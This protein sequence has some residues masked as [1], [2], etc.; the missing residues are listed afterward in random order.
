[1][2]KHEVRILAGDCENKVSGPYWS[3]LNFV[4]ALIE[5]GY[6]VVLD[7]SY[8]SFV[9]D[10]YQNLQCDEAYFHKRSLA[11]GIFSTFYLPRNIKNESILVSPYL[12]NLS[13][14]YTAAVSVFRNRSVRYIISIRGETYAMNW[15]KIYYVRLLLYLIQDRC[16]LHFLTKDELSLFKEKIKPIKNHIVVGN[17]VTNYPAFNYGHERAIQQAVF[18]RIHPD[19]GVRRALEIFGSDIIVYGKASSSLEKSFLNSLLVEFPKSDFAGAVDSE[20]KFLKLVDI[21]YVVFLTKREGFPM[22][23]L[24]A[25][26]AGCRLITTIGANVPDDLRDFVLIVDPNIERAELEWRMNNFNW[27]EKAAYDYVLKN[28]QAKQQT[29]KIIDKCLQ[30]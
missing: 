19:K 29:Q 14:L 12:L 2:Q 23:L 13:F 5:I 1:M 4:N 3:T 15:I 9:S 17:G 25:L 22:L 24:D 26:L 11:N 10:E 16:V 21:K 20:E 27:D 7:G 6:K 18:S 30:F 28:Y 8:K